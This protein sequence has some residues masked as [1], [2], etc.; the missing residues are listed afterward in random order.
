MT[1][2]SV[3][4]SGSVGPAT[5]REINF[6]YLRHPPYQFGGRCLN[7]NLLPAEHRG[8]AEGY[9]RNSTRQS[10]YAAYALKTGFVRDL[11]GSWDSLKTQLAAVLA[12]TP[13]AR[14]SERKRCLEHAA[15]K[16]VS[17]CKRRRYHRL[18]P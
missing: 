7:C 4:S 16:S 8:D 13:H 6:A 10:D 2:P 12:T 17:S 18:T 9:C 11:D 14:C 1:R 3:G 5:T 15:D